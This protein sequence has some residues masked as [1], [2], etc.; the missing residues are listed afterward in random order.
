MLWGF[1]CAQPL[2]DLFGQY[3]TFLVAHGLRET[4]LIGYVI[5]LSLL[6][7]V[8]VLLPL[9]MLRK[10]QPVLAG[11]IAAGLFV[12]LLCCVV[13]PLPWLIWPDLRLR[14]GGPL[15]V[16][17]ALSVVA[18]YGASARVREG[19]SFLAIAIVAFPVLFLLQPAVSGLVRTAPADDSYAAIPEAFAAQANQPDLMLLVFDELP[20]TALTNNGSTIDAEL[21]PNFARLAAIADFYTSTTTV[22]V[23]TQAAVPAILTGQLPTVKAQP[24]DATAHPRNLFSLLRK[25]Y[26]L[27]VVESVTRLCRSQQGQGASSCTHAR[28]DWRLVALDSAVVLAHRLSPPMLRTRLP[29]IG[30]NWGGFLLQKNQDEQAATN[31]VL[32]HAARLQAFVRR[33]DAGD[34]ARLSFLHS[35]LP[36]APYILLPTGE[37]VFRHRSIGLLAQGGI[38][39]LF[40]DTAYAATESLHLFRWQL[41][42]VDAAL[43]QLL[44]RLETSGRLNDTLLVLTADHGVSLLRGRSR[45]EPVADTLHDI[46]RVPLFIKRVGQT[47]PRRI[48]TPMQTIDVLPTILAELGMQVPPGIDGRAY[49]AAGLPSVPYHR[50]LVNGDSI[51]HPPNTLDNLTPQ[52]WWPRLH[53]SIVENPD[54]PTAE[55][56]RAVDCPATSGSPGP[57]LLRP[58]LYDRVR[59]AQFLPAHVLVRNTNGATDGLVVRFN[60]VIHSVVQT[61]SND[62]SVFLHPSLFVA[63]HNDIELIGRQ[64]NNWCLL[65]SNVEIGRSV[66]TSCSKEES[67]Q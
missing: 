19:C 3:P 14:Y 29:S 48:T 25:Y 36:H 42:Y 67:V 55:Q 26:E 22:A 16:V 46:L 8:C 38:T 44:D 17:L 62:S 31:P 4:V 10:W 57:Q 34:A 33:I 54:I 23:R 24:P 40:A 45:R 50:S 39:D 49:G 7:P 21:F 15:A 32:D 37:Q 63:G 65:Y 1:A 28:F 6:L 11:L 53:Q 13:L 2:Y 35:E 64:N 66:G 61:G 47:T 30:Q 56:L 18:A 9:L 51:T 27:D 43:G 20:L 52:R 12:M 41:G 60:K 58:E 59:P 5:C